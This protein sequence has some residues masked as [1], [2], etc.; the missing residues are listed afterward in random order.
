MEPN[1]YEEWLELSGLD[2]TD[3]NRGWYECPEEDRYDYIENNR[4]WWESF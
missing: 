2:D 1:S 3:E 4:E